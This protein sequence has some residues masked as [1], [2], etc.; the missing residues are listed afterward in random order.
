[1]F[2]VYCSPGPPCIDQLAVLCQPVL[3][4]ARLRFGGPYCIF[5]PPF[6]ASVRPFRRSSQKAPSV[7]CT[8]LIAFLSSSP[9]LPLPYPSPPSSPTPLHS[10]RALP[11]PARSA[12]S[13]RWCLS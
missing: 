9:N 8:T 10:P 5:T 4:M 7:D 11:L 2:I 3:P 12:R 1:M 6:R 13:A